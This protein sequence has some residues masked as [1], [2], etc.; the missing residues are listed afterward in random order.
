MAST[1]TPQLDAINQDSGLVLDQ[2]DG[3]RPHLVCWTCSLRG[4]RVCLALYMDSWV[5]TEAHAAVEQVVIHVHGKDRDAASAWTYMD[6]A[7]SLLPL[8]QQRKVL[9]VAPQ[10]FN[11]LDKPRFYSSK[12]DALLVWKGNSWGDGSP[13]IRRKDDGGVSS[14]EPLDILLLH[15]SNPLVYPSMKRIVFSGHSLGGQLIN[16]YCI[17]SPSSCTMREGVSVEYVIMN[18]ASYLYF[19]AERK[20]VVAPQGNVYKY[21][22]QNL[23]SKLATY[24]PLLKLSTPEDY[25]R[26]FLQRKVH[27]I[28]GEKDQGLG[29]KSLEAMSQATRMERAKNYHWHLCAMEKRIAWVGERRWTLDCV[30]NV[31]HDSCLMVTSKIAIR[32]I[33]DSNQQALH[34]TRT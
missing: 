2:V 9:V 19:S 16:R 11:G 22:L 4:T 15:F 12:E 17:L 30:S 20:Q 3:A 23:H 13:S 7:R 27:L 29:D 24:T 26:R 31:G 8:E 25:L 18:P 32:R 28:H 34:I 33:F 14:F 10:F 1:S 21:G 6:M 5:S